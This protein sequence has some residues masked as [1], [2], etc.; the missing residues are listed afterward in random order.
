M[1]VA[2]FFLAVVFAA[3]FTCSCASRKGTL[4]LVRDGEPQASIVI[5]A[6][7]SENARVAAEELQHYVEKISGA[8]LPI[9]TDDAP[10]EGTVVLVG[11]SRLTERIEGLMIPSGATRNLREEGFVIRCKGDRL[12]LAGNDS[13]PYLGTRYAVCEL[14]HRLGVR[15]FMPG[16]FGEVVPR[17]ATIEIPEMD[18]LD[19]PD[20]P[21]RDYWTHSKDNMDELLA[22][23]KIHNKMNPIIRQGTDQWF[24]VPGDG[25]V[26]HYLPQDQ[27]QEHPEWFALQR[28]GT[29]SND[30]P[31]MTNPDMINYVAEQIKAEARAGKKFSAFAPVD[32]LPRCYCP[33]CTAMSNAFDILGANTRDPWPDACMSQEWFYFVKSILD[34][35]NKESPDHMIATNG[36]ANRDIPPEIENLN[37]RGNLVIMFANIAACTIHSYEDGRCWEMRRQGQMIKRW[38]ELCDKVWIYGYNMTML[39]GKRTITPMVHRIRV[40]IPLLKEW[41]V[42]GFLDQDDPDWSLCGI[43][44]K[45]VRARLEWDTEADVDAILE[46]FFSKWYGPA[47]EPMAEFYDALEQAFATTPEHGHEDI[48]LPLIYTDD[49]LAKLGEAILKAETNATAEPFRTRVELERM[50]Y[51][52]LLG[53]MAIEK[54]KQQCRYGDAAEIVRQQI[55]RRDRM[56]EI[57]PFMG[58]L[59]F[60]VYGMPWEE[61][62]LRRLDGKIS[63][64][65]GELVAVLPEEAKFRTDRLDDGRYERWQ[66]KEYDDSAWR[67]IKTTAGWQSQGLRDEEGHPYKSV[68]WYRLAVDVPATAEGKEVRIL[69][70]AAINEVWVWVNG[71]YI[72]RR[73]FMHRYVRP[74]EF[75]FDISKAIEPGKTNQI[76]I[77]MLCNTECFGANG[78]YERMFLYAK[79]QGDQPAPE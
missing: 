64:P 1:G 6:E 20:F 53:H 33:N 72:G 63:G 41:G 74:Q 70:P 58:W 79:K 75:D 40:N 60:E 69:G 11:R 34:E 26:V 31:C 24:A 57:T 10:V 12:V 25:S 76:A 65:E 32:G 46:D 62:R 5:A 9:L 67:T 13:G 19:S 23:W 61:E 56:A 45:I 15:W 59:A 49:L 66:D 68:A 55:E 27:F 29:R 35:V 73:P 38:C 28:D 39:V 52:H 77:R 8:R 14:L 37:P 21:I 7:A 16:E 22:E 54:A 48:I 47:A 51:D 2:R 3:A 44:T 4:V 17:N 18:V 42:W 71:K 50:I 36:Y 43:P 30:M 78:I